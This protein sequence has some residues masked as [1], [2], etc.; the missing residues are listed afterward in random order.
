MY[1]WKVWAGFGVPVERKRGRAPLGDSMNR[2]SA[3]LK[4]LPAQ[5]WVLVCRGVTVE[6]VDRVG[7]GNGLFSKTMDAKNTFR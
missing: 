4:G 2:R 1:P 3:K 6:D 5:V 7:H